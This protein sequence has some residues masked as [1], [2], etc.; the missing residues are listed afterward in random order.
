MRMTFRT[1]SPIQ[2]TARANGE[3]DPAYYYTQSAALPFRWRDGQ[4]EILLITSSSGR[5]WGIPKGICE[6]GLTP[7]Q[8]ARIEAREEAGIL[9]DIGEASIGTFL[10]KKWGNQ[11]EVTVYP[12]KVTQQFDEQDWEEPHRRREWLSPSEAAT[13]VDNQDLQQLITQCDYLL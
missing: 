1:G 13:R 8:S 12:M 10:V 7:Q 2:K 6:P 3:N 11:C 4:P 5:R 9:G